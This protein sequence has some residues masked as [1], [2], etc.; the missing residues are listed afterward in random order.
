MTIPQLRCYRHADREA[1][2]ACQ[3]CDRPI[4][5]DCMI[6]ASVG[7]QCPNCARSGSQRVVTPS[8]RWAKGG[9]TFQPVATYAL[10]AMNVL[11]YI[12]LLS[13]RGEGAIDFGLIGWGVD[14][15][16]GPLGV[17]EGEWWRLITGGFLHASPAHLA[18]NMFALYSLGVGLERVL[19]SFRFVLAY[20][21]CLLAGSFGA[22]LVSPNALT[23]GASGAVF[24]LFGILLAFQLS[25]G[26]P[27][28]ETRLGLVLA[29]NLGFTFLIPGIS[30]GG[31]LGGLV[32]GTLLGFA[33]FGLPKTRRNPPAALG[34]L[35][36]AGLA[37][38][39]VIGS[40]AVSFAAPPS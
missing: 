7:F 9:S 28:G 1:G 19:G 11:V 6:Q 35:A 34:W 16:S 4:C 36:M 8:A 22:L 25:R 12:A 23:V 15:Q 27:L 10:I 20:A 24:G 17:A 33:C 32:G 18:F 39:S 37:V 31:H 2:V 5:P 26:I 38:V 3:R 30:I 40:L 14:R 29:I 21:S 13:R